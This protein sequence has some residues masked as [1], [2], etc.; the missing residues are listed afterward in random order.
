MRCLNA[1]AVNTGKLPFLLGTQAP[2][3]NRHSRP[4]LRSKA[5]SGAERGL[6]FNAVAGSNEI[7]DQATGSIRRITTP[8]AS[9]PTSAISAAITNAQ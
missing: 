6:Y 4:A 8:N 1:A 7:S 2:Q 5:T 3:C 9:E